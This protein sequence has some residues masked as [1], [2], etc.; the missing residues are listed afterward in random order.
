LGSLAKSYHRLYVVWW[1][2][3]AIVAVVGSLAAAYG[4][5]HLGLG[6]FRKA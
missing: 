4:A 6:L 3:F 5:Y 2:A 1:W